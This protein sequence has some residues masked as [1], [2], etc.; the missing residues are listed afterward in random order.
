[1]DTIPVERIIPS[2]TE[3]SFHKKAEAARKY[4]RKEKTNSSEVMPCCDRI[5][6]SGICKNLSKSIE[7]SAANHTC[8]SLLNFLKKGSSLGLNLSLGL[9]LVKLG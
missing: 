7:I 3:L 4:C 5:V 6:K 2:E 9:G 1:M 8:G